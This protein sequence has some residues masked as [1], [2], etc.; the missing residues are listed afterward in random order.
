[1]KCPYC[2]CRSLRWIGGDVYGCN[3]C[4]MHF[5]ETDAFGRSKGIPTGFFVASIVVIIG[6]V[7]LLKLIVS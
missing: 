3:E 7:V 1:M 6:C 4:D 2:D 5:G